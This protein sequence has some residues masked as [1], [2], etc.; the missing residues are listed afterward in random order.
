MTREKIN[1]QHV[2]CVRFEL[3]FQRQLL[4]LPSGFVSWQISRLA[5]HRSLPLLYCTGI[6]EESEGGPSSF[7]FHLLVHRSGWLGLAVPG[8]VPII[9]TSFNRTPIKTEKGEK[10]SALS[11]WAQLSL[12]S[13]G[14]NSAHHTGQQT[15][16]E[17]FSALLY[18]CTVR[19][20]TLE[21]PHS[22]SSNRGKRL[23]LF[24]IKFYWEI[25]FLYVRMKV[26][27]SHL[28]LPDDHP[29]REG[30]GDDN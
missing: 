7:P 4:H 9:I 29:D 24:L 23:C 10:M 15:D 13:Y 27:F 17:G 30:E 28:D 3:C 5:A 18:T 19:T 11:K 1:C 22:C 25:H 2:F 21:L 6:G 20:K 16:K 8:W 14:T 26:S 12:R